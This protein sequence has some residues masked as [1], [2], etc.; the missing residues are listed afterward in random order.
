L[1]EEGA[2]MGLDSWK[3]VENE[4]KAILWFDE[5]HT[6]LLVEWGLDIKGVSG[7]NALGGRSY[8]SHNSPLR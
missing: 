8:A 7:L 1:R 3:E 5:C 6:S 2:N 4:V